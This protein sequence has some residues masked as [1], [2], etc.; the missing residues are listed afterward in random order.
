M[1]DHRISVHLQLPAQVFDPGLDPGVRYSTRLP[2]PEEKASYNWIRR[3]IAKPGSPWKEGSLE[4]L[5]HKL[6]RALVDIKEWSAGDL[7]FRCL[8]G[9]PEL[10]SQLAIS[11]AYGSTPGADRP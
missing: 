1:D 6:H 4:R 5:N 9:V 8:K 11:E 10:G 3:W 7:L 2:T